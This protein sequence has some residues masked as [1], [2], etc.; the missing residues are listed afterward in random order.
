M[1]IVLEKR[2]HTAIVTLNKKESMNALCKSFV[3]EI[4]IIKN[5]FEA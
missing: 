5:A 3:E 2:G 1:N 4:N